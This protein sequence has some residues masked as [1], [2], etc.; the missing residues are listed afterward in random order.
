MTKPILSYF[1]F[2][3]GRGED[4]RIALHATGIEFTDNRVDPKTWPEHK[5]STPFGAIPVLDRGDETAVWGSNPILSLIGRQ[6]GLH[7]SDPWEAAR[8]ESVMDAIE[9]IRGHLLSDGSTPERRA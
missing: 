9:D 5:V 6:H 4:C 3:G 1:D 7:P 8:H 2:P